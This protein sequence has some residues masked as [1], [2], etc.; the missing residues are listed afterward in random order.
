MHAL[1]AEPAPKEPA[2]HE[3]HASEVDAPVVLLY[4]PE[5][6]EEHTE[7]PTSLYVPTAQ[8]VHAEAPLLL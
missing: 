3:V 8:E 5:E 7:S 4:L 2:G 1:A 6:Q